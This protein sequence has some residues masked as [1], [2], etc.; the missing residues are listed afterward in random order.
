VAAHFLFSVPLSA[1]R[2][3]KSWKSA[4]RTRVFDLG[5][6]SG[7]SRGKLGAEAQAILTDAS[8]RGKQNIRIADGEVQK[9]QA[10]TFSYDGEQ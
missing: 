5:L 8:P 6:R 2:R 9:G 3:K 1:S 10:A 4:T 7:S